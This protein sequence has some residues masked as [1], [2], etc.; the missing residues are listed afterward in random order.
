MKMPFE[1]IETVGIATAVHK[2]DAVQSTC[3]LIARL[4]EADVEVRVRPTMASCCPDGAQVCTD[5]EIADS[6]L[7]IVMGGDGTLIEMA[8]HAAPRG[9]PLLGVD[10]GS[11]GFLAEER[12]DDVLANLADILQGRYSCE[13]RLMVRAE[14]WRDGECVNSFIGLNDAVVAGAT[15]RWL[16]RL[17]IRVNNEPVAVY[18]ADG[19]IVSTPTGST[20]Y[21]LS[22][23]GPIV[24]PD[25]QALIITPI[26]PHTL[27][28]R[29]LVVDASAVIEVCSEKRSNAQSDMVLTVDGQQT[30]NVAAGERV[31]IRRA[32]YTARLVHIR[33]TGFYRRLR[34]KLRW[35]AE[36]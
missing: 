1:S 35:G 17:R 9:T 12:F 6:G 3:E 27:Y 5:E 8:R 19:L 25:V 22:A 13:E 23:G 10:L 21:N 34:D 36:K 24:D 26:C 11:F 2:K 14:L 31:V 29:P 32:Q 16:V 20:A 15:H 28:S 4:Q 30:V 33:R 7:V 18:P